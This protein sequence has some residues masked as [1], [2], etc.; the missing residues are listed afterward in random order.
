[1]KTGI[2]FKEIEEIIKREGNYLAG[3]SIVDVYKGKD[4]PSGH[5]AFTLRVFY[6]SSEKTLTSGEVDSFHNQIRQEL[7]QQE[8]VKLR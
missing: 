1:M 3:L 8:G 7:S 4:I 2:K 6:Q 5:K